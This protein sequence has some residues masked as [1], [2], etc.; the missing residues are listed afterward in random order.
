MGA[1]TMA[2]AAASLTT[3]P[4]SLAS[5]ACSASSSIS[6]L[7][8]TTAA[9][10]DAHYRQAAGHQPIG[11]DVAKTLNQHRRTGCQSEAGG[12]HKGNGD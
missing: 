8:D 3:S 6:S 9:A 7:T 11:R 5:A 2:C 4:V 1:C 10:I 12:N